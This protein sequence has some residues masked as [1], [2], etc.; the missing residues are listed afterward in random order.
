MT[1]NP[2]VFP[3]DVASCHLYVTY[4]NSSVGAV[5]Q[6]V[7]KSL[8]LFFLDGCLSLAFDI[9]KPSSPFLLVTFLALKMA[10]GQK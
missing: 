3:Q 10:T 1:K 8:A 5:A 2:A 6:L 9:F 4:Y 7:R